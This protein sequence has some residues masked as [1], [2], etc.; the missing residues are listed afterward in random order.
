LRKFKSRFSEYYSP[1][2]HGDTEE[3]REG[4]R[5]RRREG[6]LRKILF[7]PFSHFFLLRVSVPPWCKAVIIGCG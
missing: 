1:R 4:E 3:E 7:L 6:E 2:R 5:E